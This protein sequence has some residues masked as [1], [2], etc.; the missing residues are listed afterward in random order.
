MTQIGSLSRLK[1][2]IA[3]VHSRAD[4]GH[5]ANAMVKEYIL[6]QLQLGKDLLWGFPCLIWIGN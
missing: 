1:Q 5:L 6:N 4:H 3:D 2:L